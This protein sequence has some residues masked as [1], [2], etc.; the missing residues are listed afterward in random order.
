MHK[1][2]HKRLRFGLKKCKVQTLD[3]Y[4]ACKL[5]IAAA[6]SNCKKASLVPKIL[7]A[8]FQ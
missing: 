3:L 7:K 4:P 6:T 8:T 1:V 2:K 5:R